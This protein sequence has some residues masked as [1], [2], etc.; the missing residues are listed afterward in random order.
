MEL[1]GCFSH[2]SFQDA[3]VPTADQTVVYIYRPD[4]PPALRRAS[5]YINDQQ[6]GELASKEFTW[7][8]IL[9]GSHILHVKWSPEL[10]I[11]PENFNVHI[12]EKETIFI[13]IEPATVLFLGGSVVRVRLSGGNHPDLI[14]QVWP[15]NYVRSN[16]VTLKSID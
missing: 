7:I 1:P 2:I 11:S 13:K 16:E 12:R 9:P 3:P 14:T 4:S 5:V 6:V 8:T 10:F 15:L